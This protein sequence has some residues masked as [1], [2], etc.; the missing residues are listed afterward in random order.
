MALLT[1]CAALLSTAPGP[2]LFLPRRAAG[3]RATPAVADTGDAAPPGAPPG[4]SSTPTRT[5]SAAAHVDSIGA[6]ADVSLV[7]TSGNTAVTTLSLGQQLAAAVGRWRFTQG[8]SLVYGRAADST[9]AA[10]L[11]AR[12]SVG[13]ALSSATDLL[14]TLSYE[15]NRFAGIARR[16]EEGTSLAWKTGPEDETRLEVESGLTLVQQLGIQGLSEVFVAGR[17]AAKLQHRL[18]GKAYA[19]VGAE[20]LPNLEDLTDFRL[21]AEAA[22]VAPLTGRLAVQLVY[23][24]KMDNRPEPGFQKTDRTFTSGLRVAL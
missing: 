20:F 11:K 1:L 18:T 8:V 10:D 23:S 16:F 2:R 4:A 14:T 6:T 21:N 22:L 3:P 7:A 5:D 24:L 13:F 15:R 9:N 12:G 19:R 17:T